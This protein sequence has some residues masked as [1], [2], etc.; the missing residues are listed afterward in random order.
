MFI[1]YFLSCHFV[2]HKWSTFSTQAYR[3]HH[4]SKISLISRHK[5][6]PQEELD[7][8]GGAAKL[9]EMLRSDVTQGLPTGDDLEE[10]AKEFGRNWVR[11]D[12]SSAST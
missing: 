4:K 1:F 3:T 8:V 7:K 11:Q 10:R 6:N 5:R 2:Q 9:A 12:K